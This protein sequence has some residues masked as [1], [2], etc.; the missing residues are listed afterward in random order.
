MWKANKF[1][2]ILLWILAL[3]SVGLCLWAF[4]GCGRLNVTI[5][6]EKAAMQDV[7]NPMLIWSYIL[8]GIAAILTVFLPVPQMIENPKSALGILG[9][10]VAFAL[11]IGVSYLFSSSEPLPFLPGHHPVSEW[12]IRFTDVN[13]I[14]TYIMLGATILV[15]VVTS[16]AS[17]LK[18]R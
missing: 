8:V 15:M 5:P 12:T 3:I 11:V 16:I 18:M 9:W 1:V 10:L 4:I 7:I 14:S 13:L 6:E 17:I 2:N